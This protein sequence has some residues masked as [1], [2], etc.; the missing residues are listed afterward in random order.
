MNDPVNAEITQ[1]LHDWNSGDENASERLLPFV[2][3]ELK[4]Q[5]RYL[6]SRERSDH[7]LQP[8]ALVHEAFLRISK[9]GGVN[10]Q[11]RSHFFGVAS[12]L[13]RQILVD[14]ARQHGAAKRGTAAIHLSIDDVTVPAEARAGSILA[15]HE[16][17][18]RLE[19]LDKKQAAVVEMRFFGGL[20][21]AEIA[22]ALG[23]SERTVVRSF[24]VA[25][26]W[27]YRDLSDGA[28]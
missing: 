27:L 1:I 22:E 9:Q 28:E 25:K 20:S 18:E 5:A 2:Y 8:T 13:M 23:V 19:K 3:D 15:L 11:N 7:T 4:R 14:H 26:L 6:M 17:L 21:N 12:R 16:S 10:W 24:S